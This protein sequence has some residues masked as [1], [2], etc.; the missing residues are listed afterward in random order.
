MAELALSDIRLRLGKR[1]VL[2]GVTLTASDGK[3]VALLGPAGSGKTALLRAVAGLTRP[4]A[5]KIRIG[6]QTVFDGSARIDLAPQKRGIGLMFQSDTL[7]PQWTVFENVAYCARLARAN[8]VKE[9]TDKALDLAGVLDLADRFPPQ[10]TARDLRHMT[11]ARALVGEP[12]VLLLDDPLSYLDGTARAEAR[13]WLRM[14][15]AGLRTTALVA[16]RDPVEAMAFGDHIVLLNDGM[17]EQD[18]T[19]A[20]V[21]HEPITQFSAEFMGQSNR[22]EGALVENAGTR[23][24]LEIFGCRIG[25]ITQTRATVGTKATAV[26]RIERTRIGGGPGANRIP[27]KL[28]AQICLGERWEL[29]F[30]RDALTVR[31]YASAPLRHESYHVEFPPD[32]LWVF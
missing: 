3:A 2:K 27:M 19:P 31:A 13:A 12:A 15:L 11:L 7:W 6:N 1:E 25:G 20:D 5:G 4:H 17:V 21:Y 23:A 9:R 32:A 30:A 14:L 8:D 26:I 18:G 28:L 29:V 10:L 16:T 22:L 24:S